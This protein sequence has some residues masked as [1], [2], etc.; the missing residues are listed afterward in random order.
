MRVHLWGCPGVGTEV[1]AGL[2]PPPYR[3]RS[4]SSSASPRVRG[5]ISPQRGGAAAE[6][7]PLEDLSGAFLRNIKSAVSLPAAPRPR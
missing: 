3:A 4:A 5:E 1:S 2:R 7:Q 6:T